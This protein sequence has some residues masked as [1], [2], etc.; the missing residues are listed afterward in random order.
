MTFLYISPYE[1]I[2]FQVLR[3]SSFI[4]TKKKFTIIFLVKSSKCFDWN[5][6][7]PALQT[8]AQHYFTIRPIY[9]VIW[10]VAFLT[11]GDEI[12]IVS[13]LPQINQCIQNDG[14]LLGHCQTRWI[15]I[16]AALVSY[17]VVAVDAGVEESC[18]GS[19]CSSVEP[20]SYTINTHRV[21]HRDMRTTISGKYQM[22]V[23]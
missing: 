11:T 22:D 20:A 12:V 10:V 21:Y 14:L 9:H 15:N 18:G 17:Q 5:N 6:V 4:F 8:V 16:E 1:H 19:V 7:G 23:G 3:L 13:Q 2:A